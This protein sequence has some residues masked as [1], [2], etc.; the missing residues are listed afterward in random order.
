MG[1]S[2]CSFRAQVMPQKSATTSRLL[3]AAPLKIDRCDPRVAAAVDFLQ[4][5]QH[6]TTELAA[7]A[8][9]LSASRLRHLLRQQ[10]GVSPARY[11]KGVR[12]ES[13]RNL[14]VTTFL[15]VKEVMFAAGFNDPSHFAH[16][17]KARFGE[18]PSQTQSAAAKLANR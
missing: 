10:I 9:N 1:N 5:R 7:R 15:S 8:V 18:T 2:I 17:Y 4:N 3:P 13:A 11:A 14:L 6:H 12:L 16:D